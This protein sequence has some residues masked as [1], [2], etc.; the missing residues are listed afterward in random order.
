MV[1][2]LLTFVV[3]SVSLYTV[4]D[5]RSSFRFLTPNKR[6]GYAGCRHLAG[7]KRGGDTRRGWACRTLVGHLYTGFGLKYRGARGQ[8]RTRG[9]E[10]DETKTMTVAW[11]QHV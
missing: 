4:M 11:P 3:C 7:P 8:P 1:Y 6:L 9:P 2:C 10:A 5:V